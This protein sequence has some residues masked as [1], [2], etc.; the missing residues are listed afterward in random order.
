M[1]GGMTVVGMVG[2]MHIIADI[3]VA[4]P[5]KIAVNI[6]PEQELRSKDLH[7]DI[8]QKKILQLNG[9]RAFPVPVPHAQQRDNAAF[10]RIGTLEKENKELRR[11]VQEAER[12]SQGLQDL[13]GGL[14]AQLGGFQAALGRIE[15]LPGL[16]QPVVVHAAPGTASAPVAAAPVTEAVGGEAPLFIPDEIAPKDAQANIKVADETS[17]TSNVAV[18]ASKLKALRRQQKAGGS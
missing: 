6:T 10:V 9:H 4:V 1:S 3:R 16:A 14:Q 17:T 11:K 15:S 12:R 7:R 2:G 5:F 18:S 13:L 8:T